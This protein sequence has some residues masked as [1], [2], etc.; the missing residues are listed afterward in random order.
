MTLTRQIVRP[1]ACS[2][3]DLV[4][5]AGSPSGPVTPAIDVVA[6][7]GGRFFTFERDYL[8]EAIDGTGAPPSTGGVIGSVE[9]RAS[10]ANMAALSDSARPILRRENGVYYA[11]YDNLNDS[12]WTDISA[13]ADAAK[14]A[15]GPGW[16][17]LEGSSTPSAVVSMLVR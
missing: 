17:Q 8:T 9:D 1:V 11:D 12:L 3:V 13:M 5:D 2:L 7:A 15:I 16:Y 14:Q 4:F 10:N 6:A